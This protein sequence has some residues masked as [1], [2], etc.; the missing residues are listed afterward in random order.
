[1]S[2]SHRKSVIL[3][4]L[5]R[6]PDMGKTAVMKAVFM[7]Q[8]VKGIPLGYDFSIYTYGPYASDVMED[9][10]ELVFEHF[11]SSKMYLYNNYV[12]YCL[13]V[14]EGVK[15]ADAPLETGEA[16]ALEDVV[17]F[18]HG[19]TAKELELYSTI[20]YVD[21]LYQKNK[22]PGGKTQIAEKV[23]EIKPHFSMD[24]IQA[25]YGSLKEIA[26]I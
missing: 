13:R 12:G 2:L 26:Y 19:K 7:L 18:V 5:L 22:W 21:D 16:Q 24:T 10:D 1:M 17:G 3:N 6:N 23:H 14:T 9:I 20:I 8:Q 15:Q 11:L 4:L 25:A